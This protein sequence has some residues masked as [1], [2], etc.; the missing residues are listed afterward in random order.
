MSHQITKDSKDMDHMIERLLAVRQQS[1]KICAPLEI[2][3][4]VVQPVTDVSPPKWHLAHT[5]W[6]FEAFILTKY[7]SNYKVFNQDFHYLFNSYYISAGARWSRA[8]RGNLTRPS[9][10]EVFQY[11]SYV[12]AHLETFLKSADWNEALEHV[13]EVG[14]QHEQQHQELLIYDIKF[15]LGHNPTFPIYTHAVDRPKMGKSFDKSWYTIDE[16]LYEIGF[17]GDGFCFDNE[18]GL[19]Q[20]YLHR[21]EI[22]TS[23]VTNGEYLQFIAAGGYENHVLWLSEGW[24]WVQQ[25]KIQ[26]PMYW[27][28]ENENWH[29]YTLS[30]LRTIDW[31]AP[32]S[33]LSFFEADAYAQWKD[34]RLP[35]EFEWEVAAKMYA[36]Q[37]TLQDNFIE[38]GVF[39]TINTGQSDFFGNVWEWTASAYRPY[40]YYKA[41]GGALGEYNGKFM[42]NQMVLKGGSYA[43]PKSHIRHSYRNFFPPHL[44]WMCSGLRLARHIK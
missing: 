1:L 42:I 23:Q 22:C 3:D 15:I 18:L 27:L 41:P 43:T 44:R 20:Q 25:E 39:E 14:I 36:P 31:E 11:R 37:T 2:E 16:G 12:D 10:K 8:D 19:H 32:V 4:Y 35:T 9:V 30:G 29:N 38:L 34:C 28:R 7:D 24:D 21:F 13:L 33:H 6:F 17:S 26:H 40:P 5:T